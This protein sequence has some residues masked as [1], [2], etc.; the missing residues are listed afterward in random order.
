MSRIFRLKNPE[1][2]L[3]LIE[4]IIVTALISILIGAITVTF[5]VGL[6]A[7]DVAMLRGGVKKDASYSLRLM[8]EE[9]RQSTSVTAA[10][11]NDFT[12]MADSDGNGSDET[13]TYSWS[14]VVGEDF[15]RV[16]GATTIAL[17]RDVQSVQFKY[18]DADNNLL[19]ASATASSVR[20]VEFTLQ[21]K[22]ENESIQYVSKFRPRGI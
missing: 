9:I 20:L 22:K 8:S 16:Q 10:N 1:D 13:I 7:W 3:T 17:A 4:L 2:G 5:T 15:N 11:Q 21:L 12:F 19:S 18:Y 14:G 6:R